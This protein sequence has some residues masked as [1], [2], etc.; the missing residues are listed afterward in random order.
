[1]KIGLRLRDFFEK[2]SVNIVWTCGE[3]VEFV[4]TVREKAGRSELRFGEEIL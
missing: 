3:R 4:V 1:M 2:S